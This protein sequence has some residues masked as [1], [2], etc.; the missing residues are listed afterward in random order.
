METTATPHFRLLTPAGGRY[1]T[2][3]LPLRG[4]RYG[5]VECCL[6][7]GRGGHVGVRRF[8]PIPYGASCARRE[9]RSVTRTRSL[10]LVGGFDG[11]ICRTK[12]GT[13]RKD[14]H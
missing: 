13:L 10:G 9:G 1:L 12:P 8:S 5:S 11:T 2:P 14:R 7:W 4:P 3:L 6:C